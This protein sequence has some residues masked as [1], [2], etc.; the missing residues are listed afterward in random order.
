[1]P[2]HV[3]PFVRRKNKVSYSRLAKPA[4]AALSLVTPLK[5]RS[6]RP[7]SFTFEHQ[8]NSLIWFHLHEHASGRELLQVLDQDS[9]ASEQ[10][11]QQECL[12]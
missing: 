3:R 11:C 5:S 12:L 7:L 1:M 10:R 6:N 4:H 9:F 8:L 2:S